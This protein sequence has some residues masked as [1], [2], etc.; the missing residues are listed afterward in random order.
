MDNRI[1]LGGEM[2]EQCGIVGK[3]REEDGSLRTLLVKATG[4]FSV[5]EGIN[6]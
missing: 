5:L 1:P 6:K 3:R 4:D 2:S